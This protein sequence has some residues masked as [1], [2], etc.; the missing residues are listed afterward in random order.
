MADNTDRIIN[1]PACGKPMKKIFMPNQGIKLDVC[2]DGCGGI[3]FDNREFSKFDEP[4]EDIAPLLEVLKNKN[5]EH[6]DE[7]EIRKCPCCGTDMVKNYSS[8]KKVVQIDECYNCGGK[9]LDFG[10]LEKI[11]SDYNNPS[12]SASEVLRDL[13]LDVGS[14]IIDMKSMRKT[15]NQNRGRNWGIIAGLII[16][17]FWFVDQKNVVTTAF[18]TGDIFSAPFLV[19][20]LIA[21]CI[22]AICSGIGSIVGRTRF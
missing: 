19:T 14:E 16:S 6:V 5:F 2:V 11:R 1:C 20:V 15:Y 4:N 22:V 21:V 8:S 10:E 17:I 7:T 3:Y 18:E 13:Y 12:N 9:F